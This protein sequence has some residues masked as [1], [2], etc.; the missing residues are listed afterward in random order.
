V[1]SGRPY[2]VYLARWFSALLGVTTSRNSHENFQPAEERESSRR[3]LGV[4]VR[5]YTTVSSFIRE[6]GPENGCGE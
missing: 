1:P 4:A 3:T 2:L 6:I 5:I